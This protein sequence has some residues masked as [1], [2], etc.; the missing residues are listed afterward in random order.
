[1]IC[2]AKALQF[3]PKTM[4]GQDK[5]CVI[6]GNLIVSPENIIINSPTLTFGFLP[7]MVEITIPWPM[8]AIGEN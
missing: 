6:R 4:M 2:C 5:Y 1:M 8:D 3:R 7:R